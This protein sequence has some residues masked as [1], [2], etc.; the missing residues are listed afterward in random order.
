MNT[1]NINDEAFMKTESYR[2]FMKEN[3]ARGTLRIRAYA[4]SQAIPISGVRIV[5]STKI[6][7]SNVV[8]FEGFTNE[9]G[10]IDGI[11]L[12]APKIDLDNLDI[13]SKT[14]YDIVATYLPDNV[15]LLYKVNMYE[16]V[17]VIQNINIVPDMSAQVGG[18]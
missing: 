4:A 5:I 17:F 13:P 9:S 15:K 12:P 1:Y 2:K 7:N 18:Y 6:D 10:V 16:N 11:I 3:P 8:F 14:I